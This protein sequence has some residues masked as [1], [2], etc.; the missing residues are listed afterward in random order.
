[1]AN[2][3]EYVMVTTTCADKETAKRLADVLIKARLA[4]CVQLLTIESIYVWKGEVC[5][6]GEILLLIKTRAALYD[7]L[8]ATIRENHPYEV[9]EIIQLPIVG[10]LPE[11]LHWIDDCVKLL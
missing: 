11:Y 6:E 3:G 8:A 4:A 10:G 2:S 9:P 1:M 5:D 7:N